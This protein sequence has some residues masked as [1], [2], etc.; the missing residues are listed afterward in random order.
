[1]S[2]NTDFAQV[3]S[4]QNN[5]EVT[6]N[7]ALGR[8]DAALTE[9]FAANVS[10]GNVSLSNT[11]FR[12]AVRINA[13]GAATDGRTVTIPAI[14][15]VFVFS[16][17][18][19]TNSVAVVR[20][21]TSH[22]VDPETSILFYADGTTDG[23]HFIAGLPPDLD[24]LNIASLVSASQTA[25]AGQRSSMIPVSDSSPVTISIDTFANVALPVGT[26]LSWT[27]QGN[28]QVVLDELTGVTFRYPID[29]LP[30]TRLQ[31]SVISA[32]HIEMDVWLI[33]GDLAPS[34]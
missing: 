30:A 10:A 21:S 20:G 34:Y 22:S 26:S 13:T 16:N 33:F 14:P 23:L 7:D 2:N 28:G 9:T 17:A 4:N 27:Q 32:L 15:H 5:K 18:S 6:I 25:S 24:L 31:H 19:T 1:M 8:L 3:T 12:S 11:Q 29:M